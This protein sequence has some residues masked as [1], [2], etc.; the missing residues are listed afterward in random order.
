MVFILTV[1][2]AEDLNRD[3]EFVPQHIAYRGYIGWYLTVTVADDLHCDVE[4]VLEEIA[5]P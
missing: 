1:T 4:F 5:G 2:V 3:V